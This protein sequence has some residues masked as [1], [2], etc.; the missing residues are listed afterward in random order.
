MLGRVLAGRMPGVGL[1]EEGRGQ[2]D[3]LAQTLAGLP[4]AAVVA[5]PLQRAQET[6]APIASRLGLAVATEPGLDEIDFGAWTGVAFAALE[7][8][9]EWDA[10][11][12]F[13]SSAACPG[14]ETMLQAQAR[15]V[16]CMVR[17]HAVHPDA[18]LVLVS[19]QDVLKSVLAHFLGMPLDLLHRIAFDPA[20][21]AILTLFSDGV[22]VDALNLPPGS[23]PELR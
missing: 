8:H 5:S 16:A 18:E 17:L 10:W 7:G 13:R 15:A 11:N 3:R 4:V 20:H 21:R 2:A 12:R 19:H 9:P 6:A 1:S 23:H 22:R 14:G